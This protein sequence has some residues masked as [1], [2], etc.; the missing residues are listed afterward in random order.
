MT[1]KSKDDESGEHTGEHTGA[2]IGAMA[3]NFVIMVAKYIATFVTGSSAMLA[4][5]VHSTADTG[6]QALLLLGSKRSQKEPDQAHPF[7]YGQD[8]YFWSLIVAIILFGLGGGLSIWEGIAHLLG[9]HPSG[10]EGG[11]VWWNYGVLAVALVAEGSSL[12]YTL[13]KWR[14]RYGEGSM[15]ESVKKS[16]DPRLFIPL[17]EDIAAIAGIV[18]A[19]LGVFL[20]EQLAMPA[21]DAIAS[22]VIGCI[23]GVVAFFLA[24]QTRGLLIGERM[25]AELLDKVSAAARADEAVDEVAHALTMHLSPSEILLNLGVI[26][27]PATEQITAD[28]VASIMDR[29]E[30]RVRQC[31][32]RITR[33]FIEPEHPGEGGVAPPM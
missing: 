12:L 25:D 16:K 14:E 22:I 26:F 10:G 28:Q 8:L 6:N 31:D 11:S 2:V 9:R 30:A 19:F 32:R 7:G 20:S 24:Y 3:A 4:E 1:D 27:A 13:H 18:V 33:I 21:L 5:A 15:W 23:L 29:I 17:G